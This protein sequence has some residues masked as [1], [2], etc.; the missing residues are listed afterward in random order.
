[1]ASDGS[2]R[3]VSVSDVASDGN[4]RR[5]TSADSDCAC[6]S[7]RDWL[8]NIAL[9]PCEDLDWMINCKELDFGTSA[10]CMDD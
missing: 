6:R 8:D 10:D 1:M 4:S 2:L 5:C 9:P 7:D 3:P